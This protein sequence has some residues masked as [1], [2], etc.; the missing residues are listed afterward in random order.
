MSD[1]RNEK[2]SKRETAETYFLRMVVGY[3]PWMTNIMK[4]YRTEITCIKIIN[5]K[6][7]GKEYLRTES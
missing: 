4:I 6:R 3:K 7:N 2:M 5:I 1:V